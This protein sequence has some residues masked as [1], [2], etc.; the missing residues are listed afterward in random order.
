MIQI[1]SPPPATGYDRLNEAS[2]RRMVEAALA[3]AQKRIQSLEAQI[4]ALLA[5]EEE[6][7]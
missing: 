6:E 2:F 7:E 1:T 3:E 4:A 5:E